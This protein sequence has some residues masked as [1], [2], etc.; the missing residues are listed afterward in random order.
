MEHAFQV[1][2]SGSTNYFSVSLFISLFIN[3]L[4][5]LYLAYRMSFAYIILMDSKNYTQKQSA[6]FYLKE[7][8][9]LTKGLKIFKFILVLI[10]FTIL[11]FPIDYIGGKIDELHQ[12]FVM[13]YSLF[14]FLVLGGVFE[15]LIVSLYRRVMLDKKEHTTEVSKEEDTQPVT[16]DEETKKEVL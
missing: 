14:I 15:M 10:V 13:V 11:M 3:I 4:I 9:A 1:V 12:V 16:K 2:D 6:S 8:F 5:F 7:S